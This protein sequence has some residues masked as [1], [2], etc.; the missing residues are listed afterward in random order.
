MQKPTQL[1]IIACIPVLC[2]WIAADDAC[3][4]TPKWLYDITRVAYTDLPNTRVM[5]DWP[6]K[7]IEDFAAAGVQMM[8]SRCHSGEGWDGL[9]WRSKYGEIDSAMKGKLIDWQ[10]VGGDAAEGDV[11]SGKRCLR[12]IHTKDRQQTYL[13]RRWKYRGGEQGAMLDL[14][15]GKVSY[16]YKVKSATN[17]TLWLGIAPISSDGVENTGSQ[18]SG[19]QIPAEH[20]GDGQWH[21]ATIPYDYTNNPKVKWVHTSC[22]IG[23]EAAELLIDDVQYLGKEPQPIT[24]G[25]FED[26]EPDRD[27]TREVTAL[28]HKHGI[29]YLPY[30]WAQREPKCVGE[31]H[32]E[33]RCVNAQGKPTQYYCVNNAAY[34]ELV[35]NRIVELV[36]EVGADG[37]FFDMFHARGQECY[38]DACKEKFRKLTGQEPP[39]KEDFASLLWQQWVDFKYRSIEEA[40]LDFNRAIKL[41]NPE[42][43][44]VVNTWNAWAYRTSYK[45]PHNIRN[46]IRVIENVDGLLEET[47]WYDTVDQSFFAFPAR[48]NFMNWHLAGLC[49]RK[50]A[51][52]WG[53]CSI[54]GWMPAPPLEP[55]IRVMTMMTNGAVA[56]HSVP[57]RD[58]MKTYMAEIAERD[59]YF[60]NDKLYPWCGL[61]MSEKTELW[62]GRDNPKDRYVKGVYGA[63]QAMLERHLP[64]SL[65]TD[66]ELEEGTLEDHKV[67]FMPNCAALSDKEMETVRKFVQNGGGLVATYE[68]SLYDEHARPRETFGLADLLKAKKVGEFDNHAMRVSW[69]VR[70]THNAHLYF[71]ESHRWGDD[72]VIMKTLS[73]RSVTRP[74]SSLTRHVPVHCR[75]LLVEPA[76]GTPS[77]MRLTTARFDRKTEK[78]EQTNHVAVIEATLGKGKV[79]YFPCDITWSF[80]RYGHEY[81]G[82]IIEL[83]LR[84][85]ASA[86]PPVEVKAPTIVQAMT[87]VQGDRLVVHLLNDI[88][89]TGR[90]QCVAGESLYTRRE[91]LPIH[92]IE[93]TFR[94]KTFSRFLLVPGKTRLEARS[95]GDGPTVR[96]PRLD[97]H[98]MVVAER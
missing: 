63:Y 13:N 57:G 20:I 91:V 15:S 73:L 65:V 74:E 60:K 56:A 52:M 80:F 50:R 46:S 5:E 8:F 51:F 95:T 30:Y 23:G 93:V 59:E 87:H 70:T 68:T 47:G 4:P 79:I 54:P 48:H 62:Y 97:I 21:H 3:P 84:E 37:I 10:I 66:R 16:W 49:K 12:L 27:G 36:K 69:E 90:S 83:A 14:L 82:R 2:T 75:M 7:V 33:W 31:E 19:V 38:C 6:E 96:I 43:V 44:L 85:T 53:A 94:D 88:S 29:R 89:S 22:F 61:V 58:T 9:G 26:V 32:P 25:G 86:P 28:C 98:C 1:T 81:L 78:M 24:N 18:R 42:A 11:H 67:L 34:R 72:P 76:E 35:R 45:E 39:V 77:P 64:V 40:M 41:A 55:R 92:D 71:P 17:A